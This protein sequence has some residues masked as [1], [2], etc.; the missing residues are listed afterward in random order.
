MQAKYL[1][2]ANELDLVPTAGSDF[3]GEKVTPGR[4]L[5][6][7]SMDPRYFAELE[8]RASANA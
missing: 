7:T 8:R 4:R 1:A 5:G 3:H 2:I 6:M